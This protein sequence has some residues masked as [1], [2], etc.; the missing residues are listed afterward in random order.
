MPNPNL[1]NFETFLCVA[2]NKGFT[3]AAKKLNISKAAVSNSIKL[4]EESLKIPLFIRNTRNISLTEEGKLLLTQCYRLKNELDTARNLIS[5][6]QESP[7]GTL[8]ISCN[9][10]FASNYLIKKL[11]KYMH[12]YPQVNIELLAEERMP[13]IEREQIDIVFGIN[14][15][16]P[17]D[18]VR[19]VIGKTRYVLC[20]SKPYLEKYGKPKRLKDLETNHNYIPHIGRKNKNLLV[21]LKTNSNLN[22]TSKLKSNN[23][24]FMKKC[25]LENMGIIQLHD[26]MVKEELK[27]GD[28][29]EILKDEFKE[30]IPIYIYYQRH[31]FVQPKVRNFVN[32][33]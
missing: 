20:A 24:E 26:Y 4:L 18:I 3:A 8:K 9:P 10:Y 1:Q 16:A 17:P 19:K 11:E 22:L 33:F 2:E 15:P 30:E 32:L 7:T 29:I 21:N 27:N 31:R 12:K 25:A 14:W 23:A 5:K 13:D 6:F 28:L